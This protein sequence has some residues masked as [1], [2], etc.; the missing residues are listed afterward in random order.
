MDPLAVVAEVAAVLDKLGAPYAIGGSLASSL[1]GVPRATLDA[2]LVTA[3]RREHSDPFEAALRD[4]FYV[5]ALSIREA[6]DIRSSFNL[7]HLATMLKVDVF[8]PGAD[9]WIIEEL[10][11]ARPQ[12]V[13]FAAGSVSLKFATPEDTLLYKL[14]WFRMGGEQSERQWSDVLGIVRIQGPA[15]DRSYVTR[16][17]KHLTVEDLVERVLDQVAGG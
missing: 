13:D 8:V 12:Q 7:I 17:A 9:P 6:I 1:H 3:L 14:V 10:A 15:L 16:W 2:D 5:D 4:H 11:R